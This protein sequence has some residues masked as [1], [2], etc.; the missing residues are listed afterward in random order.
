V[1]LALFLRAT[2]A[3]IAIRAGADAVERAAGLG[4]PVRRLQTT[5]WVLAT[6][7]AFVAV[8]LRAGIVGLP[9]GQVLG[10]AILVRA[11]ATAVVGRMERLPTIAA[12]SVVL[13]IVEQSVLWHW[14]EPAYVDVVLFVVVLVALLLTQPRTRGRGSEASSWRAARETRPIPRELRD[15]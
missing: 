11:L 8:F 6:V 3:G 9:L 14:Q 5:V 4:V 12:T 15:L 13:G 2:D 7:L 10:P 1:G